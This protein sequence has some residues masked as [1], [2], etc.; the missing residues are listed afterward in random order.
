MFMSVLFALLVLV[1]IVAV[2]FWIVN[3]VKAKSGSEVPPMVWTI[4]YVIIALFAL[5]A[6]YAVATGV[7]ALPALK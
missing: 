3:T 7:F 1:I 5:F 4:V 6:L 2:A